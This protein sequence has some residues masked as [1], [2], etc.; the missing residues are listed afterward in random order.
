MIGTLKAVSEMNARHII[1]A[2][3]PKGILRNLPLP[4]ATVQIWVTLRDDPAPWQH[5]VIIPV[6]W[7]GL[8]N[9]EINGVEGLVAGASLRHRRTPEIP[10]VNEED[11]YNLLEYVEEMISYHEVPEGEESLIRKFDPALVIAVKWKY[12]GD[13]IS[14]RNRMT[15]VLGGPWDNSSQRWPE[16]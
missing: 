6:E 16:L 7:D 15:K 12:S 1:E 14:D 13:Y 4:N 8:V 9:G 5:T 10:E 2:E 11:W 3:S